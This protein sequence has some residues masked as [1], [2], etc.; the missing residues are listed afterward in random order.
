MS[1]R[2]PKKDR[3]A[4]GT[5]LAVA[6]GLL[7]LGALIGGILLFSGDAKADEPSPTPDPDPDPDPAPVIDDP[8][9]LIPEPDRIVPPAPPVEPLADGENGGAIPQ[10]LR[11]EF[12]RA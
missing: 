4:G 1:R 9:P 2:D 5:A 6:G 11:D 10:A 8:V 7:G 3:A 12:L